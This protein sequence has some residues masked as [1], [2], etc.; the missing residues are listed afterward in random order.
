[1]FSRNLIILQNILAAKLGMFQEDLL[2]RM[3]LRGIK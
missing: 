1:M 2:R 3:F